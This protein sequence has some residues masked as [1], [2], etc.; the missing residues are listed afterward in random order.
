MKPRPRPRVWVRGPYPKAQFVAPLQHH[1]RPLDPRA[2]GST[3]CPVR[4]SRIRPLHRPMESDDGGGSQPNSSSVSL[5]RPTAAQ[6]DRCT[7][8]PVTPQRPTASAISA[9]ATAAVAAAE[10]ES[11]AAASEAAAAQAAAAAAAASEAMEWN[12][13]AAAAGE[14]AKERLVQRLVLE[15]TLMANAGIPFKPLGRPP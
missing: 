12:A 3:T 14:V 6:A 11:S 2:H 1:G 8:R 13:R 15:A 4:G 7:D 9:A 10:V 5:H